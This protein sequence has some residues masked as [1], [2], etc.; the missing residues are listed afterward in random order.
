MRVAV[1]PAHPFVERVF[2]QSHLHHIVRL[3]LTLQLPRGA[4]ICVKFVISGQ[5]SSGSLTNNSRDAY[6]CTVVHPVFEWVFFP[7]ASLEFCSV[8]IVEVFFYEVCF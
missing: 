7:A 2:L 6:N 5:E 1:D 8:R 4:I 3:P